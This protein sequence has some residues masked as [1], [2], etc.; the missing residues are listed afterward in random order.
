MPAAHV[1]AQDG[2]LLGE[3]E[4]QVDLHLAAGRGPAGHQPAVLA[5]AAQPLLPADSADM[6][7]DNVGPAPARAAAPLPGP[8]SRLAFEH[9]GGAAIVRLAALPLPPGPG[10]DA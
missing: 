10:Q 7:E 4:A 1:R 3:E 2:V 9:H 8:A 5:Q 6:P